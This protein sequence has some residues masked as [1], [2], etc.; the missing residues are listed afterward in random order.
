MLG[1]VGK[2]RS[3]VKAPGKSQFGDLALRCPPFPAVNWP[4][5]R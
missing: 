5:G 4:H 2:S 3:G 1:K